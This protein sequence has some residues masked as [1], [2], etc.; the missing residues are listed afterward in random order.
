MDTQTVF[1][2][3]GVGGFAREV[4]PILKDPAHGYARPQMYQGGIACFVDRVASSSLVNG[5]TV[6]SEDAFMRY[7]GIRYFNVAIADSTLRERLVARCL[8]AGA[9]PMSIFSGGALI[10]DTAEIGEGAIICASSIITANVRIGKFF[11]INLGSYVAHD[12]VVGDFVTLAPHVKC[13]G[14]I[15]IEDHVYIG[16]GAVIKPGSPERPLRIGRGA[17]IGMGAVVTRDVPAGTT[18]IGNPARPLPASG[19]RA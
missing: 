18:V 9:L 17:V 19:D 11:H 5:A 1:G 7:S 16:A 4:M 3:L 14:N 15:V 8:E 13:N 12:C 10:Y 2:L 6:M